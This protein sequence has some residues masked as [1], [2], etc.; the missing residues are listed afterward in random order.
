MAKI[1]KR[2][3]VGVIIAAVLC[4]MGYI[5][6]VFIYRAFAFNFYKEDATLRVYGFLYDYKENSKNALIK[7]DVRIEDGK[8]ED[9]EKSECVFESIKDVGDGD[10]IIEVRHKVTL[11]KDNSKQ[12]YTVKQIRYGHWMNMDWIKTKKL[13]GR[14]AN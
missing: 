13:L 1:I 7:Y 8:I 10:P 12:T 5:A 11:F 6:Y 14:P 9:F 4:V 2:L 3:L